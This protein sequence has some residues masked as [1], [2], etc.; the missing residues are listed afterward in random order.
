MARTIMK[1]SKK[2]KG[3][4]KRQGDVLGISDAAT[5]EKLPNVRH[6]PG[7]HP[8][9]IEVGRRASGIDDLRRG[10]GA[11]GIDMGAAGEGT[12]VSPEAGR[13]HRRSTEE[14]EQPENPE[15]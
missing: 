14:E 15:G 6:H 2:D 1:L 3:Q 4:N 10:A 11:T 8:A 5:G 7:E 9:G 12:D 13:L